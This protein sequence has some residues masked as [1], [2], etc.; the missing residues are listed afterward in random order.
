MG[1]AQPLVANRGT[2]PARCVTL[3]QVSRLNEGMRRNACHKLLPQCPRCDHPAKRAHRVLGEYMGY[4]VD[5]LRPVVQA[6]E[7]IHAHM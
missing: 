1:K 7:V 5:A 2:H 6:P 4:E 3:W